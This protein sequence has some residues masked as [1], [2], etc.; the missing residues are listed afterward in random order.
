ML[1]ESARAA[2]Y[3]LIVRDEVASTMEEARRALGEGDQQFHGGGAAF[4]GN[5]IRSQERGRAIGEAGQVGAI[6]ERF[7]I[8]LRPASLGESLSFLRNRPVNRPDLL[9]CFGEGI[10]PGAEVGSLD[11]LLTPTVLEHPTHEEL[12]ADPVGANARLGLFTT[13]G[14][15]LDLSVLALPGVGR[16]DGLPFGVSL[17]APAFW[18]ARVLELGAR[19]ERLVGAAAGSSRSADAPAAADADGRVLLAV[20][21]A[22]MAGMPLNHELASVGGEYLRLTRTSPEYCLQVLDTPLGPRPVWMSIHAMRAARRPCARST[23]RRVLLL[24][25]VDV[26]PKNMPSGNS[27]WPPLTA[28]W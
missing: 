5:R 8:S 4:E 11:A 1:S 3:R 14:N 2:G 15:L 27:C 12:A 20:G 18:E 17:H 19:L 6:A 22:H 21:G 28:A 16:S 24:Q 10:P 7:R 26:P 9:T 13:F 23:S 25:V